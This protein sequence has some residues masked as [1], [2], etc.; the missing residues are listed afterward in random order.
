MSKIELG[1]KYWA[2]HLLGI[3]YLVISSILEFTGSVVPWL[4]PMSTIVLEEIFPI[5]L[6]TKSSTWW[7]EKRA[8]GSGNYRRSY[9]WHA[10]N[11]PTPS[12]R[13]L[14]SANDSSRGKKKI[15]LWLSLLLLS[16]GYLSICGNLLSFSLGQSPYYF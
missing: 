14:S 2:I 6:S 7:N 5:F 1:E 10:N 13:K 16:S 12:I 8:I 15:A 11:F 4:V 3:Y 9:S